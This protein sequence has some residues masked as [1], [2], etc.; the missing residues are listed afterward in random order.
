M[1]E[2]HQRIFEIINKDGSATIEQLKNAVYAS[3]ATIRRDLDAME[4]Q[5]LVLRVWGGAVSTKKANG[6]PPAFLRNT[7][8]INAK[9]KIAATARGLLKNNATIFLPS[10]ATVLHFAKQLTAFENI[11]V[12]TNSFDVME[13]LKQHPTARVVFLG[14]EMYEGYDV[15]GSITADNIERFNAD[16]LFFSCSGITADGFSSHDS[17]RLDIIRRMQKHSAKTV[18]LVDSSKV[19]KKF[20]YNG[21]GFDKI[22]CVVMEKQPNNEK[23]TS[24]LGDKLI[25]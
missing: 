6:D 3:E 14:G 20:I 9:K 21:F 10:G 8:N 17:V 12:I 2:R 24:V 15:A 19:G 16:Y 4:R 5:G 18:L 22:D 13:V 23:L 11:V 25:I 1:K 7:S